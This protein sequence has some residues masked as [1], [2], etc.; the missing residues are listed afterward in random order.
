MT[1]TNDDQPLD[2]VIVGQGL[3]GTT[4]AWQLKW[5]GLRGIVI[6]RADGTSASKAAAGLMTPVTGKRLVPAWRLEETWKAAEEFYCRVEEETKSQF[7][8]QPGQV[9]LFESEESKAEFERRDW[10]GHPVEIRQ[11]KTLV[12]ESS[13]DAPLGGFELPTARRLD[14]PTY[15]EASHRAFAADDLLRA[16]VLDPATDLEVRS[17][18]VHVANPAVRAK[19]LIFCQGAPGLCNPWFNDVEYKSARGEILTLKIDGLEETRIVNQVVWLVPCGNGVFKAGS[20]YDFENLDQGPTSAGR[21]EI[22][23]RLKKYLK[24]PFEIIGHES[25]VRP[26]VT[27]RRPIIGVHREFPQLAIFNGLGSKGSL[28]APLVASQLVEHLLDGSPIDSELDYQQRFRPRIPRA[29]RPR[30]PRLTEQAQTLV[31]D[32]VKPGETAIDATA[33]N[34]HDTCFLAEAVRT[35]GRVFAFDVQSD[36]L[37]RT[38]ARLADVGYSN[39]TLLQRSHAE[40]DAALPDVDDGSVAALMFNLGY[41]PGG[42][43]AVTTE[44]A[45]SLA[46]LRIALKLVRS[47]GIVTV[48]AYPGHDGG[49]DE[50]GCVRRLI[51]ELPVAEFET[52]IRRSATTSDTAPMLFV[53][54]RR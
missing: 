23:K 46:A 50:T 13:I 16:D 31:R 34:G 14:V 44:T 15:L 36:A 52:S 12:D 42:D 39:V 9:R 25:G 33:G 10:S 8:S 41:L 5:R 19:R 26:I 35:E 24:L 37:K 20:T 53:I 6:D 2:F 49:N 30:V 40:M 45:S 17:E 7:L 38:A 54:V 11:S 21:D 4:L 3:A 51:E 1:T 28:L 29:D 27:E 47:G 18:V 32:V 43:H 48:L 22:V